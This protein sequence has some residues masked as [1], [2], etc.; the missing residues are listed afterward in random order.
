MILTP[1]TYS[2]DDISSFILTIHAPKKD[3]NKLGTS[4]TIRKVRLI[5]AGKKLPIPFTAFLKIGSISQK[6]YTIFF[7]YIDRTKDGY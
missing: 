2:L 1:A 4:I 7:M 6:I 3:K 5:L